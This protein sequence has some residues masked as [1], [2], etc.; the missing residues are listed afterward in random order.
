MSETMQKQLLQRG[1][2]GE[3]GLVQVSAE[4]VYL[5]EDGGADVMYASEGGA[6][7]FMFSAEA[8][9]LLIFPPLASLGTEQL[10][11][12]VA[13]GAVYWTVAKEVW[14]D[15][16]TQGEASACLFE[17][18]LAHLAGAFSEKMPA[19]Y[20]VVGDEASYHSQDQSVMLAVNRPGVWFE[21]LQGQA[22]YFNQYPCSG[23]TLL[24]LPL[25]SCLAL[26]ADSKL[27]FVQSD[28]L[29]ARPEALLAGVHA[30][31]GL[32]I[33]AF[34]EQKQRRD[35]EELLR[36][37]MKSALGSKAM[38]DALSRFVSL[39]SSAALHGIEGS[40]DD[41]VLRACKIIGA[42][43]GI[44]FKAA[45]S[46]AAQ[47]RDPVRGIA[48]ASGVR[49]RIVALKGEWWRHDNGPLLVFFEESKEMFAALP[50]RGGGYQVVHA[51]SG[52]K[53]LV[54]T[55]FAE[56][57]A[58]FAYVFY[59]GLPSKKLA[60][61]DIL[62]F[63]FSGVRQ[64]IF[65]VAAIA[66]ASALLGMAIPI[67]SA[68]LFDSVFPAAD[69]GQMVQLVVILF[70]VG[71]VTLLFEATRALAMLRIEG[72]ASSDLQAAVWDR[73]LALP[74][75][76]FRD[77]SAGD[78]AT[79]INGI[80]EIRQALSGTMI[81]T[82]ISSLFSVLNIFLLF[83]YSIKLALVALLLVMVAVLFNF[84]VG[85]FS[86][87]ANREMAGVN[88]QL[89]GLVLEYLSGISKLRMTGAESRAFA[90][91][92]AGFAAQK[93]LAMR[94]GKLAN[95][96]S[97][98]SAAF[99]VASSALIFACLALTMAEPAGLKL[100]TGDF[101]A[102]S[103]AWTIFLGSALSLV[104]TGIDL[105][106]IVS[107]YERTRPILETMPEVDNCKA[108]PGVL[109]GG[110]EL[111]HLRFSYSPDAPLVLDD[112][113]MS[114]KP[115]EFIA[116]VGA[117]GS[118]KSTLLRLLLGFEIPTHGGVYYDD[119]HLADVDMGAIRRQLGVVLQS[120]R[121][122]SG[123]I[124]SNIIGSTS[125]KLAD[126]WD[127]ARA[128]GLDQ[129]INAMPMGMHTVV[130]DG[131]GT[132]SGGQRQRL[133]IA[134][135]IANKPKIVFFDEATSALDNQ[136][137]ALV[138]ASMDRLSATRV[139][140]AHRLSTIINADRIYVLDKGKIVQSGNYEQLIRE[141]GLFADLAKRQ[142]A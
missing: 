86:V 126:A 129:D 43:I 37:Q 71:L 117:S 68:H 77:Y 82:L 107:T 63:V 122:M 57:L 25:N 100:S 61:A 135:A 137:Q 5:L 81:S 130:S 104:K 74:V 69:Y 128:C 41:Q 9:E 87:Q 102:F 133:L 14:Q 12:Q 46:S 101:I 93:Q 138:S 103:A 72:R 106:G 89:S 52:E 23:G 124:F 27:N 113:S 58:P 78:L 36:L 88:G 49:T 24:P 125:L 31:F 15:A 18:L 2:R 70:I 95:L 90:N 47:S 84:A 38:S 115:G 110:I 92:A 11:L 120:G 45:P 108:Y 48:Q 29:S 33:Q 59:A 85:Y 142:I 4:R 53:S 6:R 20:Q 98:F 67:I 109:Q 50:L 22:A 141:E 132:L 127:A 35:E 28:E 56:Q 99:P 94:A 96:N 83:Y 30:F 73:V 3:A 64:D 119:H 75:P 44:D 123:D 140:I 118:G 8:G 116:L 139:V 114:I 79:R 54:N 26:T 51:L 7:T 121:L 13:P 97:V 76:F 32:L 131:G 17:P 62:R 55:V 34:R 21:L 80:N 19:S 65:I 111:S 10:W 1:V 16:L 105:L 40:R 42:T 66:C 134:R 60:L 91:W 112:V 136:S 39:F